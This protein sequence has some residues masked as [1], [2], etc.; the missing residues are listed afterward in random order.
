MSP[1]SRDNLPQAGFH[2]PDNSQQRGLGFDAQKGNYGLGRQESYHQIPTPQILAPEVEQVLEQFVQ[3]SLATS[4]ECGPLL[5]HILHVLTH[6]LTHHTLHQ[7]ISIFQYLQQAEVQNP[8]IGHDFQRLLLQFGRM[9]NLE[10]LITF[11]R[12][13]SNQEAQR[14]LVF[15]VP[16]T[17]Q[18][19]LSE[20]IETQNL[21]QQRQNVNLLLELLSY[22]DIENHPEYFQYFL[23]KLASAQI[24]L[25]K[26]DVL[27][28]LTR[29]FSPM[30]FEEYANNRL[31]ISRVTEE[32]SQLLRHAITHDSL[33]LRSFLME[34]LFARSFAN[35]PED[36]ELLLHYLEKVHMID[37]HDFLS[38]EIQNQQ[39]ETGLRNSAVWMLGAFQ[40]QKSLSLLH[41]LLTRKKTH[42]PSLYHYSEDLRLQAV[43]TLSRFPSEKYMKT[44][45]QA[46]QDSSLLVKTYVQQI[47]EDN[48]SSQ[49]EHGS[50]QGEWL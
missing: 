22:F 28:E 49:S 13:E 44:F 24:P 15:L 3:A 18:G 50:S 5:E 31:N 10:I 6:N 32:R 40:E 33:R 48:D 29:N 41:S 9:Q 21:E 47:I 16:S 14:L 1:S 7:I 36:E 25:D 20:F 17:V 12:Q 45:E 38:K 43:S 30:L 34:L 42:D 8:G 27:L 35:F 26:G 46:K 2:S 37:I 23:D 39:H 11:V 4:F 19:I